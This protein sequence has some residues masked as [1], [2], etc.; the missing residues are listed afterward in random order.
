MR[1]CI[2]LECCTKG[3][4]RSFFKRPKTL[5]RW[6][7]SYQRREVSTYPNYIRVIW[8]NYDFTWQWGSG[9]HM[10]AFWV[11]CRQTA[12]K[13]YTRW[14]EWKY[15]KYDDTVCCCGARMGEGGSICHHGGCRS[16]KENMITNRV[17]DI[18]GG[19]KLRIK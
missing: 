6:I 17:I 7:N 9:L 15:R 14:L 2:D 5:R 10:G 11:P 4:E 13:L 16:A 19:E 3:L 8:W 18:L 12:R 1:F